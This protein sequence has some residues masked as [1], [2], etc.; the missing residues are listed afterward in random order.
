MDTQFNDG[1]RKPETQ[2]TDSGILEPASIRT[3]VHG[4]SRTLGT[5]DLVAAVTPLAVQFGKLV[6]AGSP[7]ATLT[8]KGSTESQY[9]DAELQLDPHLDQDA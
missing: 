8:Y 9:Q 1:A 5:T 7:G 6:T 2:S 3:S 4:G